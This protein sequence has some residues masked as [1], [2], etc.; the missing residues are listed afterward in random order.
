MLFLFLDPVLRIFIYLFIS[1]SCLFLLPLATLSAIEGTKKKG[2]NFWQPKILWGKHKSWQ[3][4]L[5]WEE[6]FVFPYE[7]PRVVSRQMPLR[8]KTLHS[9]ILHYL[10]SGFCRVPDITLYY[11]R[12]WHWCVHGLVSWAI[13]TM[14]GV[15]EDSYLQEMVI[16]IRGYGS[17]HVWIRKAWF[18][19]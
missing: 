4:L 17:L 14:L 2:R 1:E 19:P 8:S 11:E 10:V 13:A 5:C 9:F 16:T 15:A 6:N 7:N 12:T 18:G 3:R